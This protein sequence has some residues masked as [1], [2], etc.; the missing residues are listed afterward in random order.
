M[1]ERGADRQAVWAAA[2][3][4]LDG[5][6]VFGEDGEHFVVIEID[7]DLAE[8]RQRGLVDLVQPFLADKFI[9]RQCMQRLC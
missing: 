9:G 5:R 2:R 7:A 1:N 3:R 4:A 6:A 8:D